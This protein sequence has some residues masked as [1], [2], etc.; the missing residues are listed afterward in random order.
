M[1]PSFTNCPRNGKKYF[2][3]HI[4]D[5]YRGI[6]DMLLWKCGYYNKTNQRPSVPNGFSYPNVK[7][8]VDMNH[9]TVTWIN[10][11]TFLLE[12]DGIHFLTD[13]I[14]SKR[15]SPVQ[16]VGPSRLHTV[17]IELD[18]L[19]K[20]DYVFISHNHYDHLDDYT[21]MELYERN[22]EIV[23]FVPEGVKKWF[24]KRGISKAIEFSWWE[25]IEVSP[26]WKVTAVPAQHFSGRAPWDYNESLWL[27]YVIEIQ[28]GNGQQKR[29]YFAGDTGYNSHDFAAIG[30]RFSCMDL[31]L[32]P[33][34][35]YLPREFMSPVHIDPKEAVQ[36]HL[37]VNSKLSVSSHWKTFRL[38]DEKVMQPP[39]D[40]FL[41]LQQQKLDPKV[42]RVLDPGH[43]INW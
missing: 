14:W 1:S 33:I 26:T 28:R 34:G 38:T 29:I 15:C 20:I 37:E 40:L 27:G 13:P 21:V 42:F 17:P 12:I 32:I 16:F 31:S 36:I 24:S 19:P 7:E 25:S 23:W 6:K 18:E 10:H 4:K 22:T 5:S 9:P 3:P 35:A 2:N 43:A 41:A 30:S 39:Y 11:T 8:V